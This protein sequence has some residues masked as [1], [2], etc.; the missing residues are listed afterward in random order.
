[1]ENWIFSKKPYPK[2]LTLEFN[3]YLKNTE[4]VSQK[5]KEYFQN[6]RKMEMAHIKKTKRHE[7][8]E[9]CLSIQRRELKKKKKRRQNFMKRTCRT[10]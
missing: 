1:M 2:S 6:H 3:K 5:D 8:Y 10:S 9:K 4:V 7:E